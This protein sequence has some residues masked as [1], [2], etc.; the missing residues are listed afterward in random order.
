MVFRF[1]ILSDEVDNF[2]REICIDS[3]ATFL[4]LHEAI[5]NSVAFAKDQITSF[6]ICNDRWEKETEVT[7]IEMDSGSE[8]DNW[9][10]DSTRL[11]DLIEDEGQRLLYVF[12]YMTERSFFMELKEIIVGKDLEKAKCTDSVGNPPKQLI[13]FDSFTPAVKSFD[14]G[15]KFFGDEEFDID[16][17]DDEGFDFGDPKEPTYEDDSF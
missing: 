9:V 14:T 5:L 17:L 16:E 6:F 1:I 4:E 10:M 12:D 2:H 15:E 3:E 7:L 13:D 8:Y 11:S